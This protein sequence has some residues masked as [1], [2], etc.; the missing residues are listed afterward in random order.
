MRV[1]ND[2]TIRSWFTG[3]GTNISLQYLERRIITEWL[4]FS[5]FEYGNALDIKHYMHANLNNAE[6]EYWLSIQP[7]KEE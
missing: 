1:T 3:S 2:S 7:K 4:P 5:G 6:N